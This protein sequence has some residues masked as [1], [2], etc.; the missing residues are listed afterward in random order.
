MGLNTVL[1][2]QTPYSVFLYCKDKMKYEV[3]SYLLFV[4]VVLLLFICA[5]SNSCLI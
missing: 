3:Q 2:T 5:I 1:Q 4:L